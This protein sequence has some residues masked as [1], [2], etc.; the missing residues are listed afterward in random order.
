MSEV[1]TLAQVDDG[2]PLPWDWD[3]DKV[4]MSAGTVETDRVALVRR[5]VWD[6]KEKRTRDKPIGY[7]TTAYDKV[8]YKDLI[9]PVLDFV[10]Q[11]NGTPPEDIT[12][13]YTEKDLG[14]QAHFRIA[15]GQPIDLQIL[16]DEEKK[17][18][19]DQH[20]I[21][22]NGGD[23]LRRAIDVFSSHDGTY[24]VRAVGLFERVRCWNGLII[25]VSQGR[26]SMRHQNF[27][28]QAYGERVDEL[29]D[30]ILV[31][32]DGALEKF[33]LWQD[34]G[35]SAHGVRHVLDKMEVKKYPAGFLNDAARQMINQLGDA[36]LSGD[37]LVSAW[38][39]YNM[40]TDAKNMSVLKDVF[41]QTHLNG[42]T[43]TI[44]DEVVEAEY[45]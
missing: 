31:H 29:L 11:A 41:K 40:L 24:G 43:F 27:D 45:A 21:L 38:E 2:H 25:P 6:E 5:G 35:M 13:K 42:N 4:P 1:V 9:R 36:A 16:M 32:H 39:L 7:A 18:L 12:I 19:A 44:I 14:A 15:L 37:D 8:N 26:F 30:S 3:V 33:K 10:R 28:D 23:I 34:T 20:V 22:E 17:K